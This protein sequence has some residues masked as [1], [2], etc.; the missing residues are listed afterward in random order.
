MGCDKATITLDSGGAPATLARRTADL[1]RA[2][3]DPVVEVGP[4]SSGLPSVRENP[5]G[6]GP[7]AATAAGWSALVDLGWHGPALVVA[8]DLPL[9]SSGLLAWL[10]E[11][12]DDRSVVPV[13]A[14]RVQPLCARYRSSDLATAAELVGAGRRAM[15][16]LLAVIDA[17][18][19]PE[20]EWAGPAG[21]AT[22]LQDVDTPED[23]RRLLERP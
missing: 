21:G 8:T 11:H 10:V 15:S 12:P 2:V 13:A 9:L 7:L 17:V 1:L 18:L 3:A 22:A 20:A 14:D 19:I 6:S 5:P 16:D 4:G 23:L